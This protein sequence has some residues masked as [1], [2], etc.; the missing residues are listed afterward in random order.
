M[1]FSLGKRVCLGES[2]ARM[3]LFLMFVTLLQRYRFL[4]DGQMPELNVRM[5]ATIVPY[6]FHMRV[7]PV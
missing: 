4:P 1:I 3:E 7:Q 2:L 5:G 6:E